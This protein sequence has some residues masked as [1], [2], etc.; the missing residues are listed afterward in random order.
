MAEAEEGAVLHGPD[1]SVYFIPAAEL[2]AYKVDDES[3]ESARQAL[4]GQ[5]E[6]DAAT[7]RLADQSSVAR[8]IGQAGQFATQTGGTRAIIIVGGA[9]G[10]SC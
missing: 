1:G 10:H 3:A 4:G 9:S 8:Y 2:E 5:A 6:G 7:S